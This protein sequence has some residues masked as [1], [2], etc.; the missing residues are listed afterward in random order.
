MA[1]SAGP[2][3]RGWPVAA[4][5]TPGCAD[6]P[7]TDWG[8][9]PSQ[10]QV[11]ALGH[12]VDKAVLERHFEAN[13]RVADREFEEQLRE[14]GQECNRSRYAQGAAGMLGQSGH[15]RVD[16]VE[17]L[18]I[19]GDPM[20]TNPTGSGESKRAG[21]ALQQLAPQGAAPSGRLGG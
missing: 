8:L 10:S 20:T 18:K 16:L 15:R 4:Y 6:R 1:E 21:G 14:D 9:A 13:L 12:E 11:E 5:R 7:E 19:W 3:K 17:F 2:G